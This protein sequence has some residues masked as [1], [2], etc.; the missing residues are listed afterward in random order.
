ML[1][2]RSAPT[3]V[4]YAARTMP[5]TMIAV[6]NV[7]PEKSSKVPSWEKWSVHQ[8]PSRVVTM[9][10][11]TPSTRITVEMEPRTCDAPRSGAGRGA[12]SVDDERRD[13][14]LC[15]AGSSV[16]SSGAARLREPG[17]SVVIWVTVGSGNHP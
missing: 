3:T 14:R 9:A 2:G 15:T 4:A 8:K 5:D 10:T 16:P 17:A 12:E 7:R 11:A 1:S 13:V 6:L